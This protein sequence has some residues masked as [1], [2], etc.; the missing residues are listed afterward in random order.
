MKKKKRFHDLAAADH[1]RYHREMDAWREEH[2]D[3]YEP[4]QKTRKPQ[5][6]PAVSEIDLTKPPGRS[7]PTEIVRR[8]QGV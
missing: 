7:R 3:E 4:K 6:S 8:R 2:K 5:A 1:D